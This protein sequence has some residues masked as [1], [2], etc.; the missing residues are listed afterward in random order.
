MR[1]LRVGLCGFTM[2]MADYPRHF[3][4]VEV[5]QTFYDPPRE[6][7]LE[8]WRTTLPPAFE[9]TLKAWQLITHAATS[10]TYRRLKRPLDDRARAQAGSFRRNA[11]VEAAW[12]TTLRCARLLRASAVLFQC[13]ASFR[14]TD[15]NAEAM[16]RFFSAIGASDG[17]RYL[18]EPRGLWPPALVAALCGEL[19]LTHVVDPFVTPTVTR[20]FTYYRLHGLSGARHVYDDRELAAL[21]RMIPAEGTSYV[22]FNNLPRVGDAQRFIRTASP[23]G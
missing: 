4:V 6:A 14:P 20:G 15:E 21:D 1:D 11:T 19:G 17:L 22:M 13:P 12:R 3:R 2:A 16:R 10:S 18:W 8:R 23:P 5:Q 9:F 7:T